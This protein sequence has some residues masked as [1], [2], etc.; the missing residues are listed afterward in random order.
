MGDEAVE[1]DDFYD[2]G[3]L[4]SN[5]SEEDGEDLMENMEKDYQRNEQLDR[6]EED[7]LDDDRQN[8]LNIHERMQVDD[9]LDQ[10][11]RKKAQM[12]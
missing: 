1:D 5:E 8:E 12:G 4:K 7:G 11:E 6:Y 2:D 9:Q 10:Q 3:N